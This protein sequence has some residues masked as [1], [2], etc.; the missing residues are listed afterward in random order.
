M[1]LRT[2]LDVAEKLMV[3]HRLIGWVFTFDRARRRFGNCNFT[4]KRLS[5][6]AYL[7]HLNDEAQVRDTILHEIAHALA[8]PQAGHGPVWQ[9]KARAIGCTSM[10]CYGE[11]VAQPPARFKGTCPGCS[12]TILRMRRK[13]ISCGRC[14]KTFNP[15]FL[16]QWTYAS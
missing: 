10:R 1:D 4:H 3:E 16:F 9:E 6:S 8:G 11:E 2:A 15:A 13:R 5:L 7:V 14:S 12:Q